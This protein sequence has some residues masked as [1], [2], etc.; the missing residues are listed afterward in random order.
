METLETSISP[1]DPQF[2]ANKKHNLSLAHILRERLAIIRAGG[3]EKYR[4]RQEEQGKLFV[5]ERIERLLDP[6]ASFLELSALAAHGMYDLEAPGAGIVTGIGRVSNREVMI[7]ANDATVKGGSYFPMTVKKHLRAQQIAEENHLPC[8][9]LVDSGGAFLPLQDE[10]FPDVNHF[11]RIFYNQARMSAKKIP[12]IA[13]VMGSCTAGG[14]YV[15]A[16]SDEAIIVKGTG[17]IFLGGPPLVKAATG[18]DVTAEELGGADVHTRLSG[19]ADHFAEDDDH[20][21]QILRDIVETLTKEERGKIWLFHLSSFPPEETLYPVEEIYGILPA[22][23]RETYDVREIIA[24]LVDGSKFREFKARYGTTLVCGF[25]RIHGYPVGIIANNGV[26]FS[27][28]AL[29]ATH[30]IEL[31]DQRGIPLVFLQNITGFMVGREA[32]V[33]GIA[34]DGAKMVH[35]VANT[36]VPKLTVVIGGSFGAGNYAMSGR[37]Y[38]SRFLWMWPNAR[39]SV[40][41]GE[42]AANVLLTIKQDQLAREGKLAMSQAEADEFKRPILEKYENEGNPYHSTARLWDDGVIDPVDTRQVLG[43]ALSV[44][45]SAPVEEQGFGVFRM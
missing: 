31:C 33:G 11:G 40:M 12:Q 39:I 16:M 28:S 21:I 5:R 18:E 19:V 41:G 10:V 35:A 9:Y 15:P 37:A 6:G 20:A 2:L 17:T 22:T 1:N 23:F 8:L 27:E 13:A 3:G 4:K 38:G 43:L 25:A 30:F 7:V 34:K 29:K 24:R 32:E 44:V 14:A 26:L 42:Q 36:R 45:L